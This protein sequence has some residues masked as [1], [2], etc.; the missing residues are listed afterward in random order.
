L[1]LRGKYEFHDKYWSATSAS[2]KDL[3]SACLQVD[4]N[5]RI[6]AEEALTTDWMTTEEET[7]TGNDLSVAQEQI[8]KKLPIDKLKGA[9][10]T[11]SPS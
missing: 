5:T 4:P 8:R 10:Y 1:I 3:I 7:L 2:A 9:I 6:T 11:V